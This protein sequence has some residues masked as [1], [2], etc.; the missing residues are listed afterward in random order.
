MADQRLT[1]DRRGGSGWQWARVDFDRTG[2]Q[3]HPVSA[4]VFV[5]MAGTARCRR[6]GLQKSQ[7]GSDTLVVWFAS[8]GI[9]P[10]CS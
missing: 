10:N 4:E 7:N 8:H 6:R 9:K 5:E 3:A 1:V 2:A